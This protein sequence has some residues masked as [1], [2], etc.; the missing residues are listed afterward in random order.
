MAIDLPADTGARARIIPRQLAPQSLAGNPR[1]IQSDRRVVQESLR[2]E[3]ELLRHG[4]PENCRIPRPYRL[5]FCSADLAGR[6]R[7]P[8]GEYRALRV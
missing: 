3:L 1:P 2:A 5:E 4:P 8:A 7:L 6:T